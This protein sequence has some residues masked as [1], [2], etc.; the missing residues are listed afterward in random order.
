MKKILLAA[1]LL[2]GAIPWALSQTTPILNADIQGTSSLSGTITDSALDW[3]TPDGTISGS[4][5]I[6]ATSMTL[7]G[8]PFGPSSGFPAFATVSVSG[9]QL[10][11]ATA[12]NSTLTLVAGGGIGLTTN[13]VSGALTITSLAGGGTVTQVT[14]G[15]LS[16]L[17]T[18]AVTNT[19]STPAFAFTSVSESSNLVYASPSVSGGIPL[20]RGLVA[21]DIPGLS[22]QYLPLSGGTVTGS[23]AFTGVS[24]SV[25]NLLALTSSTSA[26]TASGSAIFSG[27]LSPV[28]QGLVGNDYTLQ[29]G[30]ASVSDP[31]GSGQP[32]VGGGFDAYGPN[33]LLQG[34]T[35]SIQK[36]GPLQ[37]AIFNII[38]PNTGS[39]NGVSYSSVVAMGDSLGYF[40]MQGLAEKLQTAYGFTGSNFG[41]SAGGSANWTYTE[42][43][44]GTA[45]RTE[46]SSPPFTFS[47]DGHWVTLQTSGDAVS[48]PNQVGVSGWR[49]NQIRFKV[50]TQPVSG[51][52]TL[53]TS[54]DGLTWANVTGVTVS[55]SRDG[56]NWT[57]T[58]ASQIGISASSSGYGLLQ[59]N[60]PVAL[61]Q[62]YAR[63]LDA[64]GVAVSLPADFNVTGEPGVAVYHL[65][66]PSIGG[67]DNMATTPATISNALINAWS[68]SL[69]M[70]QVLGANGAQSLSSNFG[71]LPPQSYML[72][73]ETPF[74]NGT[75]ETLS[76][77]YATAVYQ[78]SRL[79][80]AAAQY[81][82][83]FYDQYT[84]A[85]S[86]ANI[87]GFEPGYT[88]HPPANFSFNMSADIDSQMHL[89]DEDNA[90]RPGSVIGPNVTAFNAITLAPANAFGQ[91][92]PTSFK[93]SYAGQLASVSSALRL[94]YNTPHMDFY[95]YTSGALVMSLSNSNGVFVNNNLG[96]ASVLTV[97]SSAAIAGWS[98]IGSTLSVGDTIYANNNFN[99]R[100]NA[101]ISGSIT[102]YGLA[103][104][105]NITNSGGIVTGSISSTT[106]TGTTATFAGTVGALTVSANAINTTSFSF[107]TTLNFVQSTA[108]SISAIMTST[109]FQLGSGSNVGSSFSIPSPGGLSGFYVTAPVNL[110]FISRIVAG[111]TNAT[112]ASLSFEF[113]NSDYTG[114]GLTIL[115]EGFAVSR[116]RSFNTST[117]PGSLAIEVGTPAGALSTSMTLTSTSATL[118]NAV[119]LI[120]PS[121]LTVTG[122]ATLAGTTSASGGF[123]PS[124]LEIQSTGSTANLLTLV[125]SSLSAAQTL[126]F[127]MANASQTITP[128]TIVYPGS[129]AWTLSVSGQPLWT[130]TIGSTLTVVGAGG[131][132][133]TTSSLGVM[134][135][136]SSSGG[137]SGTV[138]STTLSGGTTGFT[139]ATT[140]STSAM[141]TTMS[142]GAT[143]TLAALVTATHS[144][145]P[146]TA[147]T[148]TN[149]AG[150]TLSLSPGTGSGTGAAS[151]VDI[152]GIVNAASGS[153]S[154]TLTLAQQ[155][156][157][158][159]VTLAAVNTT[160]AVLADPT[161]T[162]TN[163]APLTLTL[164]PNLGTGNA[165]GKSFVINVPV[166]A[167]SGSTSQ[168]LT[169][170]VTISNSGIAFANIG[171]VT[172]AGLVSMTNLSVSSTITT[173]TLSGN[174]GASIQVPTSLNLLNNAGIIMNSGSVSTTGIITGGTIIGT[175]LTTSGPIN[176]G[177]LTISG[178]IGV[179]SATFGGA[180]INVNSIPNSLGV[181]MLQ[182]DGS[183]NIVEQSLASDPRLKDITGPLP[184]GLF[185][186]VGAWWD[187]G[188]IEFHFKPTTQYDPKPLHGGVNARVL[189]DHADLS[190]NESGPDKILVPDQNT[191][192]GWLMKSLAQLAVL[193]VLGFAA[194]LLAIWKTRR[195]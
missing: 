181:N 136:S 112:T 46:T 168:T 188:T 108:G 66:A 130:S 193:T 82:F 9:Q 64:G 11:L 24:L 12:S 107:P 146:I 48:Y 164:T 134:T 159:T 87:L 100:N 2:L 93:D 21:A 116:I 71:N 171:T 47:P 163:T 144:G 36:F 26:L 102:I 63:V 104:T 124:G 81:G 38:Y 80:A 178:D 53:Q 43:L 176:G 96:V 15:N 14:S 62:N 34:K 35:T 31:Y 184:Y 3:L 17:F 149:S 185:D 95:D 90:T 40:V 74:G 125:S 126:S 138:T 61:G 186:L 6:N 150:N 147:N 152:L 5:T 97:S 165:G 179:E 45:V 174:N 28:V 68:P 22:G 29:S 160:I 118:G 103:T 91:G 59:T 79:A 187:G 142:A 115:R 166:L 137:G 182:E 18:V 85:I 4:G 106:F 195:K 70:V 105:A 169:Q 189:K 41:I 192:N 58:T 170:A 173:S 33:Y 7:I 30:G 191:I 69:V 37:N 122:S 16:P 92:D 13:S 32:I 110:G 23:S 156:G 19:T 148:V 190:A 119:A 167:A 161:N 55:Y 113:G 123:A 129:N 56:L 172:F 1:A 86:Y 78:N 8:F 88:V 72:I 109:S 143:T 73:G 127:S 52:F 180:V 158:G 114:G 50:A 77:G 140:G 83:S 111:P 157:V 25:S 27:W 84:P 153:N 177:T 175:S 117:T 94:T 44:S 67:I 162:T 20:F 60:V 121:T 154:Q 51:S 128:S 75:T 155:F 99:L 139:F 194:V 57:S 145:I 89:F 120:V 131:V 39:T 65:W 183:G 133:V 49:S 42:S 10:V 141:S 98:S 151:L 135:I 76:P 132:T 54:T 101:V